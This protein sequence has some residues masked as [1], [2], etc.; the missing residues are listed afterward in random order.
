MR[1]YDRQLYVD[2]EAKSGQTYYYKACAVDSYG[3][4][5]PLSEEISIKLKDA[6]V[7][8]K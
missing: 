1:E 6:A 5:G 3:Q 2:E 7:S 8:E 4:S